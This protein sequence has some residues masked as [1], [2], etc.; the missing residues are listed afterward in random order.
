MA[1]AV[2]VEGAAGG[3][4]E[5]LVGVAMELEKMKSSMFIGSWDGLLDTSSELRSFA[6]PEGTLVDFWFSLRI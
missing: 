4:G 3:D 5:T 1:G 6:I 2:A